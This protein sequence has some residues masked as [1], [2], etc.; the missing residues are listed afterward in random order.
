MSAVRISVDF[1]AHYLRSGGSISDVKLLFKVD[2]PSTSRTPCFP[3][4]MILK[5]KIRHAYRLLGLP[6]GN[7][8]IYKCSRR[9][10]VRGSGTATQSS[11]TVFPGNIRNLG[12]IRP[13]L[14]SG[15]FRGPPW[16][17]VR[18]RGIPACHLRGSGTATRSSR[19]VFSRN[20]RIL[21]G[22]GHFRF[23]GL[24]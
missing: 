19:T 24:P 10:Y 2:R 9:V 15:G 12:G 22:L 21:W 3:E 17:S 13:F 1:Y 7:F 14:A 18:F 20:I 8:E 6:K 16:A 4:L 23:R 11:N 5:Y